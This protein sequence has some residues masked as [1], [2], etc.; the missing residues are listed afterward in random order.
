MESGSQNTPYFINIPSDR[1][2]ALDLQ[3]LCQIAHADKKN[4]CNIST[5]T[6]DEVLIS[7][8]ACGIV[9]APPNDEAIFN[10]YQ[11]YFSDMITASSS[12]A[13]QC[14]NNNTTAQE[15]SIFVKK[16]IPQTV[17]TNLSCPFSKDPTI[18]AQNSTNLRIDTVVDSH[19]H[20]GINA[21][22]K[23]R[24]TWRNVV[25][26][27]P[28]NSKSHIRIS[29]PTDGSNNISV[30][31]WLYG[32]TSD[33]GPPTFQWPVSPQEGLFDYAIQD[34]EF[35]PSAVDQADFTPIPE[36]LLDDAI[37]SLFFLTSNS[38][39]FLQPVDDELFSAHV[40]V[41]ESLNTNT[42]IYQL[43]KPDKVAHI[44]GCAIRDQICVDKAS[45]TPLTEWEQAVV[46]ATN[47][48]RGGKQKASIKA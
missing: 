42:T 24:F 47:M 11:P 2:D 39:L 21:A 31:Q 29:P 13:Q 7:S 9:R 30:A 19:D 22:P 18:C 23:D 8:P 12:Y 34:L 46:T 48:T 37:V 26:C 10:D 1:P 28:L 33:L 3:S 17:F 6:S 25:E 40:A 35:Q 38:I 14:Y 4:L 36:L 20:F 41:N 16:Q 15:C 44:L 27:G 5:S 32:N 45:C 43:Y